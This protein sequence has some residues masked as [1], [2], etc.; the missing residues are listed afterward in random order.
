MSTNEGATATKPKATST[1]IAGKDLS[2]D[3]AKS[4]AG[5]EAAYWYWIGALPSCPSEHLDL[6]GIHFPKVQEEVTDGVNGQTN[7]TPVI[8][9]LILLTAIQ[10]RTMKER[11]QRTVI[12]FKREAK[13]EPPRRK[14]SGVGLS[15]QEAPHE[16]F[17]PRRG[18]VVTIPT[19]EEREARRQLGRP[20][21]PYIADPLDEPA[22]N[23]LFAVLCTDQ[24]RPQRGG[25]YP[26]PLSKTG[27]TW[28]GDL[29]N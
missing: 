18:S 27:L 7:R 12:R 25:Q 6:K 11:L 28:P 22:A 10:V 17:Q 23:H 13:D 9:Q 24:D 20:D 21:R 19:N 29:E 15:V 8:G 2:P 16:R 5:L 4:K 3:L 26:E 14:D 1:R